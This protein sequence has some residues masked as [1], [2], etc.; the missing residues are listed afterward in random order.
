MTP[1]FAAGP[2]EK[3]AEIYDRVGGDEFGLRLLRLLTSTLSKYNCRPR[4]GLDLAC[5]TGTVA[6]ALARRG[7]SVTGLDISPEMLAQARLK[8]EQEPHL[9]VA[10]VEGDMRQFVLPAPVQLVTCFF[11]AMNYIL[12]DEELLKTFQCTAA[13]LDEGGLFVFDLNSVHALS[14]FWGDNV[15]TEDFGDVLYIW[16]NEYDPVRRTG[17]LTATFFVQRGELFERFSEVH[18]ER[19]YPIVEVT[20]FL[21]QAGFRVLEVIRPNGRPAQETDSRHVYVA[22]KVG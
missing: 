6:L 18:V 13:C 8:A 19:G 22:R 7:M 16:Q 15:Y 5:G 21:E 12:Y 3:Y 17:T 11:D 10:F 9:Q 20:R 4:A 14:E 2:Y 1:A